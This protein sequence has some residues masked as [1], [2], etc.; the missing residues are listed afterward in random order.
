MSARPT[1]ADLDAIPATC[2]IED[3]A[4]WTETSVSTIKR[5]RRFKAFPVPEL[6]SIDK[7][8]RW[9]GQDVRRYIENETAA[10][11]SLRR[12]G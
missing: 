10:R 8:P 5:L 6:P 4:Y 7:R 9:S 12:V 1:L 2:F 3:V 11:R